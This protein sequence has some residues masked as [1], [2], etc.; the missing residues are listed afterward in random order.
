MKKVLF[1]LFLI[2]SLN[3]VYSQEI[4]NL[5]MENNTDNTEEIAITYYYAITSGNF[6]KVRELSSPDVI[7]EDPTSP[8]GLVPAKIV[9]QDSLIAYYEENVEKLEDKKVKV[10][11][12][13]V[14]NNYVVLYQEIKATT[15]L[16]SFGLE[17]GK[18]KFVLKGVAVVHVTDGL[19]THYIDYLDYTG[20][21]SNAESVK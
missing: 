2:N 5:Q 20:M 18:V 10:V 1:A 3:V 8:S 14:S 4:N 6:D 16:S 11:K 13:F 7:F 17:G 21:L 12:S 15:D 9:G 19:V